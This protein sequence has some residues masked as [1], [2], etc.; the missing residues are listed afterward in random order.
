[1]VQAR[2]QCDKGEGGICYRLSRPGPEQIFI[3][4]YVE[5]TGNTKAVELYNPTANDIV[6]DGVQLQW[7]HDGGVETFAVDLSGHQI[8]AGNVYVLCRGGAFVSGVLPEECDQIIGAETLGAHALLH[9]GN[10]AVD[11]LVHG[12]RTDVVGVVGED[13]KDGCWHNAAGKCL[14]RD[15]TLRRKFAVTSGSATTAT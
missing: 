3:S 13:P 4:E 8:R 6:M 12:V 5:G 9:D 1:M 15:A 7:H 11:L 14:T 10:D 2:G